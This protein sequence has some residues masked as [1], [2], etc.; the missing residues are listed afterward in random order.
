MPAEASWPVR[1]GTRYGSD[2]QQHPSS[3]PCRGCDQPILFSSRASYCSNACRQRAYRFRHLDPVG[4]AMPSPPR[5]RDNIVYQCPECEA[6]FLGESRCP[7]CN[8]FCRR[9]GPGAGCPHCHE[10]VAV[11]DL[12]PQPGMP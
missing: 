7:E 1:Y 2:G 8:L 5:T 4:P 12:L 10:P 9:L 6:R 11:A 3:G